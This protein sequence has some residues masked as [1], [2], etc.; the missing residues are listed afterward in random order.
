MYRLNVAIPPFLSPKM[1][2]Q[3]NCHYLLPRRTIDMSPPSSTSRIIFLSLFCVTFASRALLFMCG[4]ELQ[5]MENISICVHPDFRLP[6]SPDVGRP[7]QYSCP[8]GDGMWRNISEGLNR[9][10]LAH[11]QRKMVR[12]DLLLMYIVEYTWF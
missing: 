7:K 10:N 4:S 2:L 8:W 9:I 6:P 1:H 3:T 12:F 11:H 5:N